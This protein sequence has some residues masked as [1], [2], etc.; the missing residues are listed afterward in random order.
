[1]GETAVVAMTAGEFFAWQETQSDLYELAGGIPL[2]MMTGASNRHDRITVNIIVE[3]DSRSRGTTSRPTTKNTCIKISETQI[4][5]PDVA[6]DCGPIIDKSYIANDPRAVFEVLSPSTR[7]FDQARKLEEY[8]SVPSLL[9]I[10]LVDPDSPALIVFARQPDGGW[11][12][13]TIEGLE[14]EADFSALGITLPLTGIYRDLT[15]RPKPVGL[16]HSK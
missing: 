13:R 16:S 9:Y 11:N 5:R 10:V 7:L 4:R 1:M 12:S 2:Q 6:I 3:A 8:K 15:F 14:A